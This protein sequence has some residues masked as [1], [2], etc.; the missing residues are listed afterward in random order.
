VRLAG[1]GIDDLRL[2]LRLSC[3]RRFAIVCL[4]PD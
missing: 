2:S 1:A 3:L 4:L